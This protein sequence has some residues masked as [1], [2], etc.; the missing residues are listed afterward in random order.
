MADQSRERTAAQ[1]DIIERAV[2]EQAGA[3]SFGWYSGGSS[4]NQNEREDFQYLFRRGHILVRDEDVELVQEILGGGNLVTDDD[5]TD[6]L[7]ALTVADGDVTQALETLEREPLTPGPG[8]PERPR[9]ILAT[10]DHI[11]YLTASPSCCPA[12]EPEVVDSSVPVPDREPPAQVE[13]DVTVSVVDTGFYQDA[14]SHALTGQWLSGVD[15]DPEV[16]AGDVIH[17]YAG[18]GTF[19]AGIVRCMARS[20]TVHVQ[21]FLPQGGIIFERKIFKQVREALQN[22]A[23]DIISLSAGTPTRN[24]QYLL[25][26]ERLWE[27]EVAPLGK[28][29]LVAAAG[30]DSSDRQFYPAALPWVYSVGSIDADGVRSDFSNFGSW[31]DGWAIGRDLVNAFP[32][33]TYTPHE[34]QNLPGPDRIFE[35]G[36]AKWSGTSF[37]T[38]VVAGIIAARMAH[39][40]E[41]SKVAADLLFARARASRGATGGLAVL[42]PGAHNLN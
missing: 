26:L 19:I 40:G 13:R 29:I 1:L 12:T 20:A 6:G 4:D 32:V 31:V 7:Q 33:G 37:A 15:G 23:P 42:S 24:N 2:V 28:T 25:G 16:L 39:T 18:H 34:P 11:L 17:E 8:D 41:T 5:T 10:P 35:N 36:L 9:R 22:D 38:P 14:E 27:T 30:N 3:G 21:A